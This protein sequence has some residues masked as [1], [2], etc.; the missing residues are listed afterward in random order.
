[1]MN[2][3]VKGYK[4]TECDMKSLTRH[5]TKMMQDDKVLAC[6]SI[7][8]KGSTLPSF[9]VRL[10]DFKL[11]NISWT[12]DKPLSGNFLTEKIDIVS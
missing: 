3:F 11:A 8:Q 12:S 4:N 9:A 1:M 5:I 6:F 10:G 7:S 2:I